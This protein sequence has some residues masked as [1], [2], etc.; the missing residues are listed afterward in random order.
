[1]YMYMYQVLQPAST[2][3]CKY[4]STSTSLH[5]AQK[6]KDNSRQPHQDDRHPSDREYMYNQYGVLVHVHVRKTHRRGTYIVPVWV[7]IPGASDFK[8]PGFIHIQYVPLT[9]R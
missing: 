1:M 6:I 3:I 7:S 4:S 2:C 5:I 8:H 9:F